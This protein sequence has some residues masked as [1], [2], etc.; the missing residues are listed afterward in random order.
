[1]RWETAHFKSGQ[2]ALTY[3]PGMEIPDGIK[4]F[5]YGWTSLA[6]FWEAN[7]KFAPVGWV[8]MN[9]NA[10]KT[11][12]DNID[13]FIKF[14]TFKAALFTLC[15]R[16]KKLGNNAGGWYSNDLTLQA[17]YEDKLRTVKNRFV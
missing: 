13:R 12:D 10:G 1:M 16:L 5:P 6:K 17:E 8:S 3:S 14:P 2:F 7:P 15:E 11:A 9:E 4:K